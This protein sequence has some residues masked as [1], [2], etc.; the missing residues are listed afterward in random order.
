VSPRI[1]RFAPFV[2]GVVLAIPIVVARYPPMADLPLHEAMVSILRHFH[3]AE[4]FP[5]GLYA[6]NFGQ[7]NQLFHLAAWGLSQF[8]PTD[9]ACAIVVAIAVA[10]IPI[11]AA[12]L[13]THVGASRL[14]AL[15]VVPLAI[16]WLFT[17][18]LVANLIGLALVLAF[19]PTLDRLAE[20]P[21]PANALRAVGACVVLYFGHYAMLSVYAIAAGIFALAQPLSVRK[22]ALRLAPAGAVA[23]LVGVQ[24]VAQRSLMSP[25]VLRIG[26][27]YD[28]LLTKLM[29][30]PYLTFK[31]RDVVVRS[32]L[33]GLC[34]LTLVALFVVRAR[35]RTARTT[36]ADAH[37]DADAKWRRV[38][39]AYR[40]ELLAAAL[41]VL[42]F[43]LP[44][45]V[46]GGTLVYHRYYAPAFA[47]LA[48]VATPR[49]FSVRAARVV[50]WL[51]PTI[52]FATLLIAW[53]AFV[54]A[55]RIYRD[56]DRLLPLV[57]RGSAVAVLT[58]S[59]D[60]ERDFNLGT[61][62]G[63]VLATRGGRLH[64]DFTDT[65]HA[66]VVVPSDRRWNEPLLRISNDP[67]AFRPAHDLTRFRYVLVRS[68]DDK[69]AALT[70][71]ALEPEAR[72]V[73]TSG[74]Y[75]LFESTLDVVSPIAPDVPLP[76]PR[77]ATLR[78]RMKDAAGTL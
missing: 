45:S 78:K 32:T 54:D 27:K 7:P 72:L 73:A 71:L 17:W 77:P 12:R 62:G 3:D 58:L 23:V 59:D 22:T 28:S 38:L 21:T 18:G 76:T 64:Y 19:L 5:P 41:F 29:E 30:V 53:P 2:A 57:A 47:I 61:S 6:K 11:A 46:I 1:E 42:Y 51:P 25:A 66:P 63:R 69:L 49:D 31:A 35:E 74:A 4:M 43:V 50:R 37:P 39:H 24:L 68:A 16:G 26:T 48:I 56:L 36:D 52:A 8:L 40:F 9:R 75:Y 10:L 55:D 14:A 20:T 13:A 67:L 70:T 33:F 60:A 34:V 65:A 15:L 44:H